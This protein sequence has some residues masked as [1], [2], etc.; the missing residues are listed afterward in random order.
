MRR[1]ALYAVGICLFGAGI[2]W[3]LFVAQKFTYPAV[4]TNT[5]ETY[6]TFAV[7]AYDVI[8]KEF[9][10]KLSDQNLS[11][12]FYL[13]IARE[14]GTSTV[15]K[16]ADKEGV[17]DLLSQVLAQSNEVQQKEFT[18]NVVKLVL[19]NLEPFGRAQLLSQE[20]HADLT[21]VVTN[22]NPQTNLYANLGLPA[23]APVSEVVKAYDEKKADIEATS[24]PDREEELKKIEYAKT[25]LA[26]P[27]KKSVYDETK[28][29][30]TVFSRILSPAS[31]YFH[32][33]KMSPTTQSEIERGLSA[34]PQRDNLILDL[35]G[36]IGGD[37]SF[38]QTFLGLLHGPNQYAYDIFHNGAYEAQRTLGLAKLQR[39]DEY[40]EIVVLT[41]G[42]TQSTAEIITAALKRDHRALVVGEITR[43]W[44]SIEKIIPMQ[45]KL[46]GGTYTI[47]LVTGL[48]VRDDAEPIESRGVDP[49]VSIRDPLWK[50]KVQKRL[51]S[52]ALARDV[53][54]VVAAQPLK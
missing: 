16:T 38:A 10:K 2:T 32:V 35:R 49:D 17:K 36:N 4:E 52:A 14:A 43:G 6:K 23:E 41:D 13:A 50:E 39:L 40:R 15:L 46:G 48:T 29:E 18:T 9:W 12:L 31:A 28:V 3:Y 1:I 25:V 47:L 21:N 5:N 53:V 37:L 27:E 42:M 24:S 51:H 34:L 8:Q 45:T 7:E 44:G 19:Y 20:A 11:E 26:D 22:V 30:P 33:S 54:S